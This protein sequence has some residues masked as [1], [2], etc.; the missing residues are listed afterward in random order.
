MSQTVWGALEESGRKGWHATMPL[1]LDTEENA[2]RTGRVAAGPGVLVHS[3]FPPFLLVPDFLSHEA[4]N[5]PLL[6]ANT[7]HATLSLSGCF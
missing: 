3:L 4:E 7:S 2:E 5:S 1:C 6:Q